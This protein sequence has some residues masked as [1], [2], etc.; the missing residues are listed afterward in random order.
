MNDSS[1]NDILRLHNNND[2]QASSQR[3]AHRMTSDQHSRN[4]ENP[5]LDGPNTPFSH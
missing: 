3:T 4:M 2:D 1:S 5:L